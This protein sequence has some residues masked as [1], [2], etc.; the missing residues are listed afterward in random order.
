MGRSKFLNVSPIN[1]FFNDNRF[2]PKTHNFL[3]KNKIEIISARH[4]YENEYPENIRKW[5]ELA[6][7]KLAE[8]F[9]KNVKVNKNHI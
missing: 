8:S 6:F 2:L 1:T 4:E 9:D 5:K 3:L 7:K